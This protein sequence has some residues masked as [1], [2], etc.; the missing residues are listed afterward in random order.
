MMIDAYIQVL[1]N[2]PS[3]EIYAIDSEGNPIPWLTVNGAD[4]AQELVIR[5]HSLAI[6][7]QTV[8][9]KVMEWGRLVARCQRI[10]DI[11][12][13][14]YR[15]WKAKLVEA[16]IQSGEKLTE[17][18]MEAI[19]R[20]APEYDAWNVKIERAQEALSSAQAVL[21]G[22]RSKSLMLRSSIRPAQEGGMNP[23]FAIP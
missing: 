15:T 8:A 3:F 2:L 23:S 17:K 22:F 21:D 11:E 7:V 5:E 4:L 19:Y 6:Q 14:F 12:N 9:L 16:K 18:A 10:L 13:R 1:Q 20:S